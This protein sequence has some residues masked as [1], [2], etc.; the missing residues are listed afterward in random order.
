MHTLHNVHDDHHSCEQ[1]QRAPSIATLEC[2]QSG[3]MI[4]GLQAKES[5]ISICLGEI[6]QR[7]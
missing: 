7:W 2:E 6:E 5:S 3:G 4:G 1:V